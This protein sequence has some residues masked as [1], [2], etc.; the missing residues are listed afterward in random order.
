MKRGGAGVWLDRR[1]RQVATAL[2]FFIFGSVG[3]ICGVTMFPL[4]CLTT[5]NPLTAKR[6]A[7][8]I[9]WRWFCSR[10]SCARSA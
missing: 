7:Q 5:R 8:W 1:W 6:R 10:G 4:A 3:L 2:S 9:V